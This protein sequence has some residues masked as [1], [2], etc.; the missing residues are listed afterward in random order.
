MQHYDKRGGE[1]QKDG[2][3][4]RSLRL[5]NMLF[6]PLTCNAALIMLVCVTERRSLFRDPLNFSTFN[7]IFEVIR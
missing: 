2:P 1:E 5:N 4:K 6:S 7:M 3:A